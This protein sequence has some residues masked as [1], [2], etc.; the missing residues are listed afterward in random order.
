MCA[1]EKMKSVYR[2]AVEQQFKYFL[3]LTENMQIVNKLLFK[4]PLLLG[5]EVVKVSGWTGVD[6]VVDDCS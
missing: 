4:K 5:T 3:F 1:H 6:V 2:F